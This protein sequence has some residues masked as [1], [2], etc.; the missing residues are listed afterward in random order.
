MARL[1]NNKSILSELKINLVVRKF[2][3]TE[4][5]AYN[6]FGKRTVRPSHLI[7]KYQPCGK[8]SQ[9][10]PIKRLLDR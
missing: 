2:K 9:G 4:I 8:R 10:R 5:N 3:I 6:L 1:Q 7:M